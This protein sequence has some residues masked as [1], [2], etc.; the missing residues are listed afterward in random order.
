MMNV[1][2][3][4]LAGLLVM[5]GAVSSLAAQT[6]DCGCEDKPLPE[7]LG[8]VNGVKITKQDL[9]P[10][11]RDKDS[12]PTTARHAADLRPCLGIRLTDGVSVRSCAL[13]LTGTLPLNTSC[14]RVPANPSPQ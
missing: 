2:K 12:V 13:P 14:Y 11:T 4:I 5:F 3:K 6:V 1:M 10:E 7:V 9:S 8:V